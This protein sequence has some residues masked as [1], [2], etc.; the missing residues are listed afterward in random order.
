MNKFICCFGLACLLLA[1]A[2]AGA[3]TPVGAELVA[4]GT[5]YSPGI[6]AGDTLYVSGLQ[7]TDPKSHALPGDFSQ[8][9]R[10]CF[11]NIGRVLKDAHMSY[12]D[13]VSVQIYLDDMS[14]FKNVNAI[15]EEYF[16]SPFPARMTLQAK[17]SLGAHIEVS[18]IARK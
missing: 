1:P 13:V 18:A 6:L 16:K 10:N 8:E 14:K 5:P 2:S 17:L 12:A 15:Y 3:G 11:E 9:A 7:G 4:P